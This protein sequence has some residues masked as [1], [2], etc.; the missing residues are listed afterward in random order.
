MRGDGGP[1]LVARARDFAVATH[2]RI[3]HVRKYSGQPYDVHLRAVAEIVAEVSDDAETIAAAWLHD[4]V[5]DTPAT[6]GDIERELGAGVARLVEEL[7]DVSKPGDGNRARR[8]ELDR[9]HLAGASPRA[10]TVKLADLIDNAVDITHHDP[11]FA[12]RFL[13]EAEALVAVL[14]EGDPRLLERATRTLERCRAKLP[15][16]RRKGGDV[17]SVDDAEAPPI[18][19]PLGQSRVRRLF[20][21]AFTAQDIAEP[22][23]SFDGVTAASVAH[24]ALATAGKGVAGVRER[25][26]VTSFATV[27]ALARAAASGAPCAAAAR[28]ISAAQRIRGDASLADAIHVLTAREHAFVTVLGEPAAVLTRADVGK[29]IARMLLFGM[30]TLIELTMAERIR[31]RFPGEG[32]RP[33]VA[34]GRLARAEELRA[35]RLRRGHACELLDCL[36]LADK[37]QVLARDPAE[38]AFFGFTSRRAARQVASELESLR[39]HLAHAQDVVTH[40]WAQIARMTRRL[41]EIVAPA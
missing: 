40:D 10:K 6:L 2:R 3:D 27:E 31:A 37:A 23:H 21:E 41:A 25:G 18:A 29:P 33:L 39:N 28:P 12:A 30:V 19:D 17:A 26:A 20:A 4:A 15:P 38:L 35:E 7:T 8:K 13:A 24:E 16:P 36:Q 1:D 14:G 32:F 9:L 11:R 22:L 5:E 34:A